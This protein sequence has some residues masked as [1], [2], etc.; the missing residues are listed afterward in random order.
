LADEAELGA[1]LSACDARTKPEA[2]APAALPP[3]STA[4]VSEDESATASATLPDAAPEFP[5]P[6][7]A[8]ASAPVS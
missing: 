2:P 4:P 7:D 6:S 8:D 5:D 3:A 1:P